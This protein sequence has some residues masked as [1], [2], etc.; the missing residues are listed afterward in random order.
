[1]L[2]LL[3]EI[4]L[5]KIRMGLSKCSEAE[6][7]INFSLSLGH[8]KLKLIGHQ[9]LAVQELFLMQLVRVVALNPTSV[10]GNRPDGR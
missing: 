9:A 3:S 4:L 5:S 2:E 1:M 6:R 10:T 8:D 7:S